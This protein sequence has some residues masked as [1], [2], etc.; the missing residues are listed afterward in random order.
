MPSCPHPGPPTRQIGTS[1]FYLVS[2]CLILSA[3][4]QTCNRAK[5]RYINVILPCKHF[6]VTISD[7]TYLKQAL[8]PGCS[9]GRYSH[10]LELEYYNVLHIMYYPSRHLL[11]EIIQNTHNRDRPCLMF[12]IIFKANKIIQKSVSL[13]LSIQLA[14]LILNILANRQFCPHSASIIHTGF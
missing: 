7:T 14:T 10:R 13:V 11:K 2:I 8:N 12:I 6:F 9:K 3:L 4:N 5:N 1:T